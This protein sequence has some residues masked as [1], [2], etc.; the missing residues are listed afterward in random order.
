MGEK[1]TKIEVSDET[2]RQL[3]ARRAR[4]VS[5]AE[6]EKE[7]GFSRPVVNRVLSSDLAQD[8]IRDVSYDIVTM[9]RAINKRAVAELLPLAIEVVKQKLEAGDLKAAEMVFRASELLVPEQRDTGK[10]QQAIQVILPGAQIPES[11]SHR[12]KDIEVQSG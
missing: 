9:E 12:V 2:T 11:R 4:G 8:T 6:L 5:L 1:R 7:F 10:Q 3:A